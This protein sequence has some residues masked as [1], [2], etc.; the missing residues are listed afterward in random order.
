M[1]NRDVV[2]AETAQKAE[3]RKILR[4]YISALKGKNGRGSS[5]LSF[6]ILIIK[7]PGGRGDGRGDFGV[8]FDKLNEL[9]RRRGRSLSLSKGRIIWKENDSFLI[10]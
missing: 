1:R 3:G 4:P 9:R 8:R 5:S 7:R 2:V 10:R 6:L